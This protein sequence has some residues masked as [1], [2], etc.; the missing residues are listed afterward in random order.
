MHAEFDITPQQ[1]FVGNGS[2][3]VLAHAFMGLLKHDQPILLTGYFLQ[4]LPGLLWPLRHRQHR[5]VA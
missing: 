2:D 5:Y 1:I 4:F 3:E